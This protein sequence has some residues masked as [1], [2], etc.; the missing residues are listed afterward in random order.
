MY[1]RVTTLRLPGAAS[2][3]DFLHVHERLLV[4]L[5]KLD[6]F[7]RYEALIDRKTGKAMAIVYWETELDMRASDERATLIRLETMAEVGASEST[8]EE[9]E[10]AYH[11]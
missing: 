5:R 7:S 8:V 1:A 3:S 2:G 6:G 9:Y 4:E 11:T 10:V